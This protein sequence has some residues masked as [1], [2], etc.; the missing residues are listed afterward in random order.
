MITP[1]FVIIL[2]REPVLPTDVS[3]GDA[4]EGGEEGGEEPGEGDVEEASASTSAAAIAATAAIKAVV[5]RNIEKAQKHQKK[6][7]DRRTAVSEVGYY[8]YST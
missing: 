1:Y 7:Y 6:N 8:V 5:V 4:E 3:L 2:F